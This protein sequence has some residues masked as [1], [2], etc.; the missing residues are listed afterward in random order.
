MGGSGR[1]KRAMPTLAMM[2]PSRTWG[3]R[4]VLM[5]REAHPDCAGVCLSLITCHLSLLL[6]FD[7]AVAALPLVFEAGP[8]GFDFG[9]G[10]GFV[11]VL[12]KGFG[13][14]LG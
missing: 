9:A 8:D 7:E 10:D 3:T 5:E 6:S 2:K 12:D 14:G 1:A 4:I 11:G 13:F